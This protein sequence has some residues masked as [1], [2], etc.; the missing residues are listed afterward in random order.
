MNK[1]LPIILVVALSGCGTP[2]KDSY[3]PID[4]S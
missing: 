4:E 2:D 1:I 3:K